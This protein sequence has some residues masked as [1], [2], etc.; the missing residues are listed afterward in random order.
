MEFPSI[1]DSYSWVV[2]VFVTLLGW[3][4]FVGNVFLIWSIFTAKSPK[5]HTRTIY[6]LC[7]QALPD[8]LLG[9]LLGIF[10][11]YACYL[12]RFPGVAIPI[13]KFG[14]ILWRG[15]VC[16][17]YGMLFEMTGYASMYTFVLIAWDRHNSITKS[18]AARFS[19]RRVRNLYFLCWTVSIVFSVLP[20]SGDG[21]SLQP[22]GVTCMSLGGPDFSVALVVGA[23]IAPVFQTAY[24]YIHMYFYIKKCTGNVGNSRAAESEKIVAKQFFVLA[25]VFGVLY[26]P[27]AADFFIVLVS[28]R[29]RPFSRSFE[30]F[31][32]SA[33]L[34]AM[35]NGAVNPLLVISLNKVVKKSV[36]TRLGR[37]MTRGVSFLR[38]DS[39]L[40]ATER[41]LVAPVTEHVVTTGHS[42]RYRCSGGYI[43]QSVHSISTNL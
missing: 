11:T 19:S 4:A 29:E 12:K 24:F 2:S 35:L 13:H 6:L 33:W 1:Q 30:R 39:T 40:S 34:L 18:R 22:P 20:F 10:G 17:L 15:S 8:A 41:A 43:S 32:A 36:Q 31:Q 16:S 3:V 7:A 38:V 21:Y 26:L 28:S 23:L 9:L 5:A 14:R 27:V 42:I 37:M 25:V